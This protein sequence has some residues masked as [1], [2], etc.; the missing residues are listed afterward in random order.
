MVSAGRPPNAILAEQIGVESRRRGARADRPRFV[1][2]G[3]GLVGQSDW[4]QEGILR[5]TEAHDEAR[6]AELLDR[7]KALRFSE[8]A[9]P[10]SP[11]APSYT[12]PR[13]SAGRS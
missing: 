4:Q 6:R 13:C 7:D 2:F 1:E 11:R 9:G 8:A 10:T 3:R 12:C 5:E